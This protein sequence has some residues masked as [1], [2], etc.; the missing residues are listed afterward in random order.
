MTLRGANRIR[1][2]RKPVVRELEAAEAGELAD[3]GLPAATLNGAPMK[4][5]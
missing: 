3:S 4:S 5:T 2:T 1:Q